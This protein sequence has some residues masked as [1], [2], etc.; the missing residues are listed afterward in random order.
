MAGALIHA[1]YPS[2]YTLQTLDIQLILTHIQR[3]IT[4]HMEGNY[5]C[6]FPPYMCKNPPHPVRL[7]AW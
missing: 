2:A 6:N 1:M 7:S 5:V 4:K 3:K